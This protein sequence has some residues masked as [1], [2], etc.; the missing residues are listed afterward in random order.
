MPDNSYR[1]PDDEFRVLIKNIGAEKLESI[2]VPS[3]FLDNEKAGQ[4]GLKKNGKME[5]N[6]RQLISLWNLHKRNAR[7]LLS[8]IQLEL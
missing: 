6:K 5:H 3:V 1:S 4:G 8:K 7:K 2:L